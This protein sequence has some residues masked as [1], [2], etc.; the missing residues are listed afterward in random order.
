LELARSLAAGI[1]KIGADE[2][3]DA[4]VAAAQIAK[5]REH[6]A[7]DLVRQMRGLIDRIPMCAPFGRLIEIADDAADFIEEGIFQLSLLPIV[8]VPE[9]LRDRLDVLGGLIANASDA[10]YQSLVA[11]REVRRGA[12]REKLHDFLSAIDRVVAAEHEMDDAQRG[13]LA[14]LV[15]HA[16]RDARV[17]FVFS[18]L[19][20]RL[21]QAADTVMHAALAL[22]D[23]VMGV[24]MTSGW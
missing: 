8:P 19:T 22:R 17:T 7:D 14:E 4:R 2:A 13:A 6:E 21:E 24:V 5:Q 23:E 3:V 1:A 18:H 12:S 10:Y 11:A 20:Y 16:D 9:A 15:S